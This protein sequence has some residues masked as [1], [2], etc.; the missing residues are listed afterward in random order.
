MHLS[1]R[2][3]TLESV[4]RSLVAGRHS[5][6][7]E[8]LAQALPFLLLAAILLAASIP[9]AIKAAHHGSAFV[10]WHNQIAELFSATDVYHNIYRLHA[11]PNPPPMALILYPLTFL[12][13]LGG[14][15]VWY[16]IKAAAVIA[17]AFWT[18]RMIETPERPFPV[19]AKGLVLLL[20][21]KPILGDLTHGNVNLFILFLVVAALYAFQQRRDWT[22]GVVLALAIACKVTPL[23]FVPYFV[24]KCAWKTLGGCAAGMVCFVL[25]LPGSLLGWQ[26]NKDLLVSW[27]EMMANPYLM[28]GSVLY[29]QHTNQSLPAV[30]SRLTTA[31]P[32]FI[33]YV[34]GQLS[35][36]RYDNLLDIGRKA[37]DWLIRGCMLL[38]AGLVMWS[39]R[40]PLSERRGW[41]LPAEFGLV[42]L[43]MLLC[44]ERT[45]KHHCVSLLLPF[46]VLVYVL[47]TQEL[48]NRRLRSWLG[49][50][51]AVS[52]ILMWMGSTVGSQQAQ[53]L[54]VY[55]I[56]LWA[57]LILVGALVTLLRHSQRAIG[58][59]PVVSLRTARPSPAAC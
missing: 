2:W 14:A 46:A 3:K 22:A 16:F 36:A 5:H 7:T 24:W 1:H 31:K 28:D 53:V 47:T 12:S 52:A 43:G 35:P 40:T 13:P 32:S 20:A 9:Y 23:L 45:W 54:E 30:V 33:H 55:G 19:W 38:F 17:A 27:A 26:T 34:D 44:S 58:F 49:A 57:H 59:I 50:A 10:R 42:I 56:Y 4:A 15:L 21:L 37:A 8:P 6:R 11:Y 41:R 39:C 48:S 25:L 18:F 51:L 29:T